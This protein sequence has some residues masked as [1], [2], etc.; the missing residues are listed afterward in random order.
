MPHVTVQWF[1]GRTKAQQ[2]KIADDIAAIF[3]KEAG[4][5][6][7]ETVVMFQNIEMNDWFNGRSAVEIAN[8]LPPRSE[9][10]EEGI[11]LLK[12]L[13]DFGVDYSE[14]GQL[15]SGDAEKD[16]LMGIGWSR[17]TME[18]INEY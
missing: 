10:E 11:R 18:E 16:R 6:H 15:T 3:H 8:S 2:R 13:F 5:P 17:M 4:V 12:D 14:S 1:A 9:E 7:N